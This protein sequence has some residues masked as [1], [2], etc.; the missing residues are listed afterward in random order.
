MLSTHFCHLR[1]G[2]HI[3]VKKSMGARIEGFFKS[4]INCSNGL[5]IF[6]VSSYH[7]KCSS[8]NLV[9]FGCAVCGLALS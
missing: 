7:S 9:D 6:L 3:P 1:V 5:D 2:V 4:G 8:S